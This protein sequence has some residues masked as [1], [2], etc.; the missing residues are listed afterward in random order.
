MEDHSEV[1]PRDFLVCPLC[2]EEYQDPKFLPCLHSFCKACID[3]H[4]EATSCHNQ[5]AE[6]GR[7]FLCPV[8]ATEIS[9][10]PTQEEEASGMDLPDNVFAR[11]LSCPLIVQ[12]K[13]DRLCQTCEAKQSGRTEATAHCINCDEFLC[14]QC[15]I[16]HVNEKETASHKTQSIDNFLDKEDEEAEKQPMHKSDFEPVPQCCPLY[17]ALDIGSTFCMD[18]DIATCTECHSKEHS[19]HRCAEM[20]AIS[21]NFEMKIKDP[22]K[23]LKKDHKKLKKD[24]L[25]LHNGK[26]YV[27]KK[28][29]ELKAQA[30][31]R[32]KMLWNMIQQYENILI[33]EIEKRHSKNMTV[34]ESQE[35]VIRRHL[36]S[37]NAVTDLTDKLL[38]FGSQEEKVSMRRQ[39]G[40]RMREL[41]EGDLPRR[42]IEMER[43]AL[44]EPTVT[45]ESI[46]DMFGELSSEDG[47]KHSKQLAM[48]KLTYSNSFDLGSLRRPTRHSISST[49][50]CI[51]ELAEVE[52]FEDVE[53]TDM[54]SASNTSD[55]I[56]AVTRSLSTSSGTDDLKMSHK[57]TDF[58]DHLDVPRNMRHDVSDSSFQSSINDVPCHNLTVPKREMY[59]P[60]TIAQDC[61]KGVG[62]T[63]HGDIVVG[64]VSPGGHNKVFILEKH[65][66]IR[67]QIPVDKNW[68]IHSIAGDGTVSMMVARSENR[69]KVKV[70]TSDNKSLVEAYIESYGLSGMAATKSG[71]LLV[72]ATRYA[73]NGGRST[74]KLGGNITIFGQDSTIQNVITNDSFTHLNM[75]LFDRPH[76]IAVDKDDNFFIADPGRHSVIGFHADG[77]FM[78]EY[79]NT[80][81]EEELY[82]GPD[83]ICTDKHQNIIVLDRKD[84]RID[85]LN[86][87]GQL[88]RCYF[89]S[90]HIRF[91]CANPDKTLLLVTSDGLM[92]FYDYME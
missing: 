66:I 26:K 81:A 6:G 69:Y 51:E 33:L 31:Q 91:V 77:S 78:F 75:Y 23:E 24:L 32:S 18:C 16:D 90:E 15:S 74:V 10:P 72:S 87:E 83:T 79:G 43:F 25:Y 47:Q 52:G 61:I 39:I 63:I 4:I 20:S 50:E 2:R 56:R 22:L 19:D 9:P 88:L 85:V 12:G 48:K 64:T 30:R 38:T 28:Q 53:D 60:D 80:D 42:H 84:G 13:R 65:G 37:I 67:G 82:Q 62:V 49:D 8:C 44:T 59:F 58:V 11:R 92:K 40:R 29:H 68:G 36:A 14:D 71:Q 34:I 1:V 35:E 45:V 3:D 70:I 21:H 55:A 86:Y 27:T 5:E 73:P 89:P 57:S 54:L 17:D 7:C 46:C 76:N 41:C